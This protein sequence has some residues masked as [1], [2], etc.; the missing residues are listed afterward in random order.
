L[1]TGEIAIS[2]FFC[3]VATPFL[4]WNN[5]L[6]NVSLNS[7]IGIRGQ[8]R[9]INWINLLPDV[10]LDIGLICGPIQLEYL[11]YGGF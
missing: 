8:I 9:L 1:E 4:N 11:S 10:R 5:S 3:F 2:S 7:F 6:S